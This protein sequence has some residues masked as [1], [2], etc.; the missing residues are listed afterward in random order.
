MAVEK[1]RFAPGVSDRLEFV[2][3][4]GG[5][6]AVDD[7]EPRPVALRE[8]RAAAVPASS[9]PEARRPRILVVEDDRLQRELVTDWLGE[10]YEVTAVG[11]GFD[12]LAA[13][14]REAPDLVVLDLILPRVTGYELLG[15]MRRA[16]SDVPVLVASS[17]VGTIGERLGPLVLG[18]TDFIEKPL[19]RVELVHKVET[20]LRLPRAPGGRFSE[21]DA[22]GLFGSFARS[23]LLEPDEFVERLARA[24][25][26]GERYGHPSTVMSVAACSA[27]DVELWIEGANRLLRFEDAIVRCDECLALVLLVATAPRY[28]P[29]VAE[30]LEA[31]W[32]AASQ[33]CP[34]VSVEYR[35][36]DPALGT[37]GALAE[38]V[39]SIERPKPAARSRPAGG[40]RG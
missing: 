20:L 31:S 30:R 7:A 36:A 13:L 11:D 27:D 34:D 12:A 37:P 33:A 22:Q 26:F 6:H 2:I 24:C 35:L 25:A 21:S 4:A 16:H 38:L 15:A 10:D 39:A 40:A 17:R 3:A 19:S 5:L 28:A 18:A 9:D 32:Q 23:R 8:R 14:T 29:R 1:T